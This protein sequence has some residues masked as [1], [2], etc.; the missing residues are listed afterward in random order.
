MGSVMGSYGVLTDVP[1][2]G[3]IRDSRLDALKNVT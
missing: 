1:S 3:N 2:S